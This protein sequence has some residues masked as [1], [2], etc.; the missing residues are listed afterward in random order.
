MADGKAYAFAFDDVGNNESLAIR[1]AELALAARA[2]P[3]RGPAP[4]AFPLR[5]S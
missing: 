4:L 1:S 3:S 5:R 2:T